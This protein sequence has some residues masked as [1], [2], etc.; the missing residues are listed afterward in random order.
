MHGSAM[1]PILLE[2]I[3]KLIA[4][5]G[6]VVVLGG[7][8]AA[9]TSHERGI[10]DARTS[11]RYEKAIAQQG[12]DAA[13]QIAAEIAKTAAAEKTLQ[14]FKNQ[15]ELIDAKNQTTVANLSSQLL[16][17]AGPAGQL[18]DP[19]ATGCRGGSG[20]A[21]SATAAGADDRADDGAE[22]GGLLSKQLTQF[23]LAQAIDAD[24]INNAYASCRAD[25]QAVR[26]R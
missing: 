8:Y 3:Y 25:A 12:T 20:S 17:R 14:D 15:Q 6:L 4:A 7:G 16:A 26:R 13:K 9:W 22:A 5:L 21:K 18:R 24:E 23:L 1:N 11:V 10:G 19:N 2:W